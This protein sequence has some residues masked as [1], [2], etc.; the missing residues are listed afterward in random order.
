MTALRLSRAGVL[1]LGL[2]S[3]PALADPASEARALLAE[4]I[5]IDTSNPPGNEA[6]AARA[7]A[8]HLTA[9]GVKSEVVPF[10]EGRASLV[11]RLHGDGSKRPLLL[12][13]HLDVVG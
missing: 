6:E 13:A 9:A 12:L 5:A 10:G 8:A 1:F 2:I 3:T 7:V 4:L 11:A